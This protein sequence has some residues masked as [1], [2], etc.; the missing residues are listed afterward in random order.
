MTPTTVCEEKRLDSTGESTK[1]KIYKLNVPVNDNT[2]PSPNKLIQQNKI[3]LND[4]IY[5]KV[6][7]E[8]DSKNLAIKNCH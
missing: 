7:Q 3:E 6:M 1:C 5:S 2:Y 4:K 8:N